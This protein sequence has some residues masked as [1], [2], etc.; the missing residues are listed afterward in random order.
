M[1]QKLEVVDCIYL[2][3]VRVQWMELVN[4]ELKLCM[5]A[6]TVKLLNK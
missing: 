1:I 3:Q 6:N 4:T 5:P 2:L